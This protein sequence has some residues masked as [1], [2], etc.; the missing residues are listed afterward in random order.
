MVVVS[1]ASLRQ[2]KV[3]SFYLGGSAV[4]EKGENVGMNVQNLNKGCIQSQVT[5]QLHVE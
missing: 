5:N 1:Y 3:P 4:P 2:V